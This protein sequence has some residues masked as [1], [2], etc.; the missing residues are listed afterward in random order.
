MRRAMIYVA[1]IKNYNTE[2]CQNGVIWPQIKIE[3]VCKK[4]VINGTPVD[5]SN[6]HFN[7]ADL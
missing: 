1:A 5:L 6:K 3:F 4:I 7:T 2:S